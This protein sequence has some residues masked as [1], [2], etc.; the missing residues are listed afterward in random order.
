[1]LQKQYTQ[2]QYL[3]QFTIRVPENLAKIDRIEKIYRS[4]VG[5]TPAIV[6]ET[7][8]AQ[9]ERLET[10]RKAKGDYVSPLEL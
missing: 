1:M 5:D 6:L 2:D 9:R 10:L 8:A 3:E 7:L 4:D